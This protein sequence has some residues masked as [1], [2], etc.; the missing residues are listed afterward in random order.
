MA[1]VFF[2]NMNHELEA[3]FPCCHKSGRNETEWRRRAKAQGKTERRPKLGWDVAHRQ[4]FSKAVL[5]L[6]ECLLCPSKNLRCQHVD[7]GQSW[8]LC[9]RK[10]PQL[11]FDP[12]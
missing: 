12:G 2:K 7:D 1:F 9:V 4:G 11:A 3:L 10:G 6:M 5:G 8:E